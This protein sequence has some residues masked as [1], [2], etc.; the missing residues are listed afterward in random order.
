MSSHDPVPALAALAALWSSPRA[1][2][3][4]GGPDTPAQ[5]EAGGAAY[6]RWCA[7]CHLADLSGAAEAGALVG[8]GFRANW[9]GRPAAELLRSVRTRMPPSSPGSLDAETYADLVAYILRQNG[10]PP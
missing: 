8:P 4:T 7:S 5:A 1:G 3:G 2:Q 6:Q 10:V 9:S